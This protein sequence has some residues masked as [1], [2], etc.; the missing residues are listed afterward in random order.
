[1]IEYIKSLKWIDYFFFCLL[2]PRRLVNLIARKEG[3]PLFVGFLIVIIVSFFQIISLSMFGPET[4][5]FYY[6]IS[7]GW[8]FVFLIIF[9]QII[10]YS[11]LIDLFCQFRG[12]SGSMVQTIN[13][14]CFS[15]LPV[16]FILPFVIIFTAINFAPVFFYLLFC[17]ILHVWQAMILITGISEIHR[18][19]FGESF[20]I[21][22]APFIFTC[23]ITFFLVILFFIN[24][25]GFFSIL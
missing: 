24:I 21:F 2:D 23:V 14:V 6:K 8:I 17:F 25:A 18:I 5:F 1:M 11:A 20:A 13:V 7:Y 10:I 9:L 3:S 15:F 22:L 12:R 19:S 16:L 4:G